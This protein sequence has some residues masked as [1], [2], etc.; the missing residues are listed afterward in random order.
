M[1]PGG[2]VDS[3]GHVEQKLL[4]RAILATAN[5][6]MPVLRHFT[7]AARTSADSGRDLVALT[8]GP[9]FRGKRGYYVGT[10]AVQSSE[11]SLDEEAQWR[12][13]EACWNWTGLTEGDTVLHKAAAKLQET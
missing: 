7:K 10:K 4:L 13:W 5:V 1:D 8:V 3:R 9:E 2:I 12:V 6:M 11:G